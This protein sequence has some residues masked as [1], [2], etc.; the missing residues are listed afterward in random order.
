M[1]ANRVG[2]G[3]DYKHDMPHKVV[4]Q[5]VRQRKVNH[6]RRPLS[7]AEQYIGAVGEGQVTY[8]KGR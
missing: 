2:R 6:L 4:L 3:L 7:I 8:R 5:T 1:L